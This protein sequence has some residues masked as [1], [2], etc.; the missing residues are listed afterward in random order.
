MVGRVRDLGLVGL[1]ARSLYSHISWPCILFVRVSRGRDV[2]CQRNA[3]PRT[4]LFHFLLEGKLFFG[5]PLHLN[6]HVVRPGCVL[7]LNAGVPTN[8]L[9]AM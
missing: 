1:H 3:I 6:V 9:L 7:L 4:W 8:H 5:P 2:W